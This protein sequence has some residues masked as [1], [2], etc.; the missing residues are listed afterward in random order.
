M[1][2]FTLSSSSLILITL[3]SLSK[4][5]LVLS[6]LELP[7][8]ELPP[9]RVVVPEV[10]LHPDA[11]SLQGTLVLGALGQESPLILL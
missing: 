10:A 11:C 7:V 8:V 6:D 1:F 3:S 9:R 5:E 4:G 2:I